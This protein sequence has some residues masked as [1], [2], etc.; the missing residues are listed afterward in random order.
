[1]HPRFR[2]ALA[3]FHRNGKAGPNNIESYQREL[4][5]L[6]PVGVFSAWESYVSEEEEAIVRR[7]R[8]NVSKQSLKLTLQES[9][10][11]V[12]SGDT[13]IQRAKVADIMALQDVLAMCH[14]FLRSPSLPDNRV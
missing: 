1:M 8:S 2:L 4:S 9:Q 7:Q 3:R 14:R 13:D 5:P 12:M 6:G 11:T 10:L